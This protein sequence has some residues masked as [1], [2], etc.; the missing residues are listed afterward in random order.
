[1]NRPSPAQQDHKLRP[2]RRGAA[3]CCHQRPID[4][5]RKA[6]SLGDDGLFH[7][8][9]CPSAKGEAVS[10]EQAHAAAARG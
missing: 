2:G 7:V 6:I 9:A 1:M 3:P 5:I 10:L 8:R 4:E